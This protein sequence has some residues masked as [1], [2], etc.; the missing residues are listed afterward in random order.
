M[1]LMKITFDLKAFK[2]S[3]ITARDLKNVILKRYNIKITVRP[4][5]KTCAIKTFYK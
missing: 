3:N 1:K 4:K 2:K 5:N